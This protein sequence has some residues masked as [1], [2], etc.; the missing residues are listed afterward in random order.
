MDPWPAFHFVK[1]PYDGLL[2]IW[3]NDSMSFLSLFQRSD[4]SNDH[5]H[6]IRTSHALPFSTA[7]PKGKAT[8]FAP[9]PKATIISSKRVEDRQLSG[10]PLLSCIDDW[11][12][13]DEQCSTREVRRNF[14]YDP[15][16]HR[17][18]AIQS[19]AL[20]VQSVVGLGPRK[21]TR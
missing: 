2:K 12:Q 21:T 7:N 11:M 14:R 19:T 15:N 8:K 17:Y 13:S 18:A 10:A 20:T 9:R 5:Q 4:L 16:R 1:S 6:I 3:S